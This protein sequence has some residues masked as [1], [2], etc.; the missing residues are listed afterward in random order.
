MNIGLD[1]VLDAL[2]AMVWTA[3][4]DGQI[5]F[6]NRR[7]AA[8]TG[9]CL[10]EAHG[11]EW[12]AAIDPADLPELLERW[13]S[14]LASGKP[15][16][17]EGRVRRSDG[18]FRRFLVQCSP[19]LDDSGR[20][21]KWCG[22]A[23]DVEDFQRAKETSQRHEL[24]FQ[25]IVDSIPVPVAVTTPSGELEGVNRL[26]IDY[27][28]K[29]LEEQ[30]LWRTSGAVHPDDL[31][32]TVSKLL[33]AHQRG[34]PFNVETRHR[35]ADGV[36]RWFNVL[37]LPLRAKEGK[38]LRWFHL[39][40]DIDDRKRAEEALRKSVLDARSIIDGIPGFI[41]VLAPDGTVEMV[42]PQIVEYCG[43]P[44]EELRNWGT[45]GTVHPDDLPHVARI[46]TQSIAAGVPYDI[47]QRLR[48]FDGE[49]RWFGNRGLPMRDGSGNVVRW[50][51]LLTDIHDRKR[52]EDAVRASERQARL[53]VDSIPGLIAVFAPSGQLEFVNHQVLEYYGKTLEELRDWAT[54]DVT[55]PDDLPRTTE[56]FARSIESGQP[57]EVEV[58]AK[59]SDGAFR[60]LQSRVSPLRDANGGIIRWYNLLIDIDER[61]RAETNLAG[62]K[63]LLEMVATGRPLSDV[64]GTLCRMIEEAAPDCYCDVHPISASGLTFEY[65]VAP[66]LPPSYTAPIRGLPVDGELLPCG[67][68]AKQN[69]QVIAEDIE[70]DPRWYTSH[71]R[72]HALKHGLRSVWSTPICSKGGRVLGTFCIYQNKPGIP[73]P[74]HQSLIAHATHI[75]SIA[76]ERSRTEAALRRSETLLGE[77]QRLSSTGAFSWIVDTDEVAFSDELNRIFEFEPNG[78]VTLEQVRARVHP[79]DMPL[80]AAQ[81]ERVRAGHDYVGYEIR[82]RM[83]DGRIKYL[84]TFGR[85][86]RDQEGRKEC[87]ASVQ[88]VTERR[89]AEQALDKVRSELAHVSRVTSLGAM[90]ASIAHE[91]NQPLAGIITNANTCLRMLAADPPNVEG[92]RKTARR[93]IR[94]GN[95]AADV[96]ARLR[97]LFSKRTP[98]VEPVDLNEAAREVI[99]LSW[100]DLQRSRVVVRAELADELPLVGGDRVQLQ[101]VI[102][103]LLRNASDAMSGVDDRA[104]RLV[105]RTERDGDNHVRLAVEDAGIGL[106]PPGTE[107]L[108][109]AFYTT[110]SDGMG[111]GLSISR[112]IIESHNGRI[113]AAPNDGPGAT[114]AFSIPEYSGDKAPATDNGATR[115]D[116]TTIPQRAARVS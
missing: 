109:E 26:T 100:S 82:L 29:T 34:S 91:V 9:L 97:A 55:H 103:N 90:T 57:F 6:V 108:F 8:Y 27:F 72:T 73:S 20:I 48:R 31:E 28:G 81:M 94:D 2:P 63:H 86:I 64:L 56:A 52:A 67:V 116:L 77:G 115:L 24:D 36:Y 69:I 65:G 70:S 66:S 61:K 112:S 18:E 53:M 19:M 62:E 1:R 79:E 58:R 40:I 13:R 99:A 75:A 98:A 89:L 16:E 83:P 3:S 59:R 104:R 32:R 33:E 37:G 80:M 46:F 44:L 12:Q 74:R 101:Q 23:T 111:I 105:I 7:W 93:T 76:I 92:A 45:N 25:L 51:V 78:V 68:A 30:K 88:D 17:L 85:V 4:A 96:I 95:R 47:E 38:I 114:F 22:L 21:V 41:A 11:W 5:D 43:R 71:V 107:R 60:W 54:G 14:I 84:R 42:N 15:G 106:G 35:R 50:Y 102:V 49:Y 87:L 113:W 10:D 110:K 39:L